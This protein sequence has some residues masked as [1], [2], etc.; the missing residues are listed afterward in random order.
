MFKQHRNRKFNY[1]PRFTREGD[2]REQP[3]DS[4]ISKWN[5]E[6]DINLGRGKRGFSLKALIFVLVLLLICMYWLEKKI[7]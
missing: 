6:R 3:E 4:F 7:M 1:Q 2:S 5:R